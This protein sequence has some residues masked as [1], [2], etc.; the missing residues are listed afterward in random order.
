MD[1]VDT[2]FL[3]VWANK[4]KLI[5]PATK[6][7]EDAGRGLAEQPDKAICCRMPK[8]VKVIKGPDHPLV[9][10]KEKKMI[11]GPKATKDEKKLGPEN[12]KKK[13]RTPQDGP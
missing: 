13:G 4:D 10:G 3:T 5:D 12:V 7:Q 8:V 1:I 11:L 2:H 9:I 6:P